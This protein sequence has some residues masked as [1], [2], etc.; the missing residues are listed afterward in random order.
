MKGWNAKLAGFNGRLRSAIHPRYQCHP[1][2]ENC[3]SNPPEPTLNNQT[4][5]PREIRLAKGAIHQTALQIFEC[6]LFINTEPRV[7]S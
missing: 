1:W 4:H 7:I 5:P 2:L 3:D 6:E